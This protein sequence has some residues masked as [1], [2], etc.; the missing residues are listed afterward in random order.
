VP[1]NALRFAA[2]FATVKRELAHAARQER[3]AGASGRRRRRALARD[4]QMQ[5]PVC[6]K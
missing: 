4:L 5:P 1:I 6:L 3:A 2:V